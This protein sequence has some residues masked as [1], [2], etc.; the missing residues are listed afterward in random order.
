MHVRSFR[1]NISNTIEE[2]MGLMI[3]YWELVVKDTKV[4]FASIVSQ[5]IREQVRTTNAKFVQIILRMLS[6]LSAS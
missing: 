2:E 4:C 3:T 1:L 5:A 6:D